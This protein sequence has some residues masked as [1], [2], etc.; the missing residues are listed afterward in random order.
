[1]LRDSRILVLEEGT[2][3][4]NFEADNITQETV[5]TEFAVCLILCIAYRLN[6]ILVVD[7]G[8]VAEFD[9]PLALFNTPG[10]TKFREMCDSPTL[11]S[12]ILQSRSK[13]LVS[14]IFKYSV[15]YF[16]FQY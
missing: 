10:T 14:A 9:A 8:E 2:S 15:D 1:M 11:W 12:K 7:R 16:Y 6:T 5:D 3:S 4:I 13:I